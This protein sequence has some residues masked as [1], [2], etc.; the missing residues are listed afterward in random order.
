MRNR[1]NEETCS[2]VPLLDFLKRRNV[3]VPLGLFVWIPI[4]SNLATHSDVI[5]LSFTLLTSAPD[6]RRSLTISSY[7]ALTVCTSQAI[8][9]LV[10]EVQGYKSS[11]APAMC[12][13]VHRLWSCLLTSAPCW[14]RTCSISL[15]PDEHAQWRAVRPSCN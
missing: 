15:A 12:S 9:P 10:R 11:S 8:N 5:P 13:G 7:P 1:A 6:S 14:T 2:A 3:C 4:L